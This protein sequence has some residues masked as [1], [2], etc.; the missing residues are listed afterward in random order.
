MPN[1]PKLKDTN[2]R[3]YFAK[4][5]R[6]MLMDYVNRELEKKVRFLICKYNNISSHDRNRIEC[7]NDFFQGMEILMWLHC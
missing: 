4:H 3:D 7:E 6:P 2:Q 5:G 1:E